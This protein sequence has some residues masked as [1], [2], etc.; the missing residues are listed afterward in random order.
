MCVATPWVG[1]EA[2]GSPASILKKGQWAMS[3]SGGAAPNRTL[4]GDAEVRLYQGGHARGYGLTDW[5]SVYGKIGLAHL[6][7]DD[8]TIIKLNQS[9]STN[10]FGFN[11]FTEAQIKA[12]LWQHVP[13]GFEWD[14]S[15]Q[16]IDI[17]AGHKDKNEGRWHEWQFASSVAKPFGRVK[18][19]LGAKLNLLRMFYKVR[20]NG[21][22][23]QQGHYREDHPIGMFIGSDVSLGSSEDV[24][25]NVETSYQDGL[26]TNL[27]LQYVF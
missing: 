1:A 26:E 7:V 17:R 13:T 19:Y 15:L 10:S 24:V 22:V 21:A 27:A 11:L 18:P 6:E 4:H 12:R 2:V 5:L 8:P 16:Y 14:G 20:Q 9:S 23:V 3:A 25:L